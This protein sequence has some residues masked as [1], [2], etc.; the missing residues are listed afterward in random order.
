MKEAVIL[1]GLQGAGKSTFCK[2]Y[3]YNTH[4]R[5]NLDMLR[6][7]HREQI[8]VQACCE[9]QQSFVVDNTNPLPV[10]RQRYIPLAKEHHFQI[11]GYYFKIHLAGCKFRNQN[12]SPQEVIPLAGLLATYKKFV[13]PTWEEGFDRLYTVRIHPTKKFLLEEWIG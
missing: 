4:I 7:R 11:V 9:A 13:I 2:E 3:F 12:R 1:M 10:D 8:L 5:I 6:T